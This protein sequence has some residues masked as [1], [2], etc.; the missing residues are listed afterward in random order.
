MKKICAVLLFAFVLLPSPRAMAKERRGAAVILTTR[1]GQ[2]IQGELYAV[3]KDALTIAS[4]AGDVMT[5][6]TAEIVQVWVKRRTGRS[7]RTGAIVGGGAGLLCLGTA[8][9][10]DSHG[11][12]GAPQTEEILVITGWTALCAGLGGLVGWVAAGPASKTFELGSLSGKALD[13]A[14]AKLRKHA[15]VRTLA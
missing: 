10:A 1:G 7:I 5:V 2:E 12:L 14:L 15:R 3:K 6:G 9:A 4:S 11:A 13:L 8:I